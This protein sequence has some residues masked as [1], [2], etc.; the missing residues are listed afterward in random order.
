MSGLL[1]E[2]EIS[3]FV[4]EAQKHSAARSHD[5]PL[6]KGRWQASKA[7]LGD[8]I[9]TIILEHGVRLWRELRAAQERIAV[10]EAELAALTDPPPA[11]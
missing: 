4:H 9:E 1:S 11:A 7:R 6:F 5:D 2:A 3:E 10:L 8:N